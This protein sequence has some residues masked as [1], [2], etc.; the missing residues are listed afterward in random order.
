[1]VVPYTFNPRTQEAEAG[2]FLLSFK[3]ALSAEQIPG[4]PGL[5]RETLSRNKIKQSKNDKDVLSLREF[6]LL[7]NIGIL[8]MFYSLTKS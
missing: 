1:M 4:K 3:P 6:L 7:L 2:G 5:Q 8:D